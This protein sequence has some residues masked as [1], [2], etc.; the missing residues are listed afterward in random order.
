[1]A[2]DDVVS[3]DQRVPGAAHLALNATGHAAVRVHP[4]RSNALERE[5]DD[6]PERPPIRPR[7][8]GGSYR[9]DALE[10]GVDAL[11]AR[12]EAFLLVEVSR[13][14]VLMPGLGPLPRGIEE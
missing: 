7:V 2:A 10:S 11:D 9:D 8:V 3:L 4:M 1:M 5:D 14:L 12:S 6:R 13:E